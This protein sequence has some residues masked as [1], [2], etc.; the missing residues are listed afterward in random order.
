MGGLCLDFYQGLIRPTLTGFLFLFGFY[1][2]FIYLLPPPPFQWG[3]LRWSHLLHQ[4][5]EM[6]LLNSSVCCCHYTYDCSCCWFLPSFGGCF[7]CCFWS[8]SCCC[9]RDSLSEEG[10]GHSFQLLFNHFHLFTLTMGTLLVFSSLTVSLDVDG[11]VHRFLLG[12]IFA[13]FMVVPHEQQWGLLPSSITKIL[14]SLHIS[15]SGMSRIFFLS[16]VMR[17]P[18]LAHWP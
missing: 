4:H 2:V 15:V 14:L 6:Q 9:C 10:G 16:I 12:H 1:F 13:K 8:C 11:C 18:Q 17:N 5:I 3:G 7:S